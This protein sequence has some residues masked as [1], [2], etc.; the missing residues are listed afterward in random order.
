MSSPGA[1]VS[2]PGDGAGAGGRGGELGR[3]AQFLLPARSI[4]N[5]AQRQCKLLEWPVRPSLL[6]CFRGCVLCQAQGSPAA[7]RRRRPENQRRPEDPNVC[8]NWPPSPQDFNRLLSTDGVRVT[9]SRFPGPP[10]SRCPLWGPR[11]CG[12]RKAGSCRGGSGTLGDARRVF[13]PPQAH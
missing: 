9:R 1:G 5:A 7:G 3:G 10:P 8:G 11:A 4:A 2:S 6:F 13:S 12:G